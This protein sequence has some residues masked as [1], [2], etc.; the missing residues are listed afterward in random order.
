MIYTSL[1]PYLATF[2]D[3]HDVKSEFFVNEIISHNVNRNLVLFE[4][5]QI[6]RLFLVPR[7][8]SPRE[9]ESLPVLQARDVRS[10]PQCM[11]RGLWL[12]VSGVL[13]MKIPLSPNSGRHIAM[14]VGY[15]DLIIVFVS[16]MGHHFLDLPNGVVYAGLHT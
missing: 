2:G 12:L 10:L 14:R 13:C 7:P 15:S 3:S 5:P 1:S 11:T 9:L 4:S 6:Q 8:R 16:G